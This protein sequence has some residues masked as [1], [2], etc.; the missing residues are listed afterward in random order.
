MSGQCQPTLSA[1]H[2]PEATFVFVSTN[3]VYGD[4]PNRLP[5]I[6]TGSRLELPKDHRYYDGI[7]TSRSIDPTLHSLFGAAAG[8]WRRSRGRPSL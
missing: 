1:I 6:D 8:S 3:K 7:D 4:T 5:L 2:C